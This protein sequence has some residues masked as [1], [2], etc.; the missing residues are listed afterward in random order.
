M[1][2]IEEYYEYSKLANAA[3]IVLDGLSLSST[4]II[5]EA[6][7]QGRIPTSLAEAMFDPALPE[8]QGEAVWSIPE[9]GYYGNDDT[10][11]AATLFERDGEKVLAIRGT[12]PTGD[13]LY[14]DLLRADIAQIG[15]I[16]FALDQTVSMINHI[17]RLRAPKDS[18]VI[19]FQVNVSDEQT[20]NSIAVD[21]GAAYITFNTDTAT[22]YGL[23]GEDE[24]ITVTG[25][26]LGGHLAAM[27]TRLFPDIVKDAYVYNSPGFDPEYSEDIASGLANIATILTGPISNALAE[28][29]VPNELKLTDEFVDFMSDLLPSTPA[30]SFSG[31]PVH[32][33]ESE[34]INPND[35]V[36]IVSSIIT[37]QQVL[38]ESIY[39]ATEDNSHLIEPLMDSLALHEMVHKLDNTTT[40]GDVHSLYL[41]ASN[42]TPATDKNLITSIYKLFVGDKLQGVNIDDYLPKIDVADGFLGASGIGKG[43]TLDRQKHFEAILA[44]ESSQGYKNLIGSAVLIGLGDYSSLSVIATNAKNNIAYRYAL[45]NLD[46][47]VVLGDESIYDKHNTKGELELYDPETQTGTITEE[48]LKDRAEFLTNYIN[49]AINDIT[50]EEDLYG[51]YD[52]SGRIYQ[53]LTDDITFGDPDDLALPRYVF[54]TEEGDPIDGQNGNDHLYGMGGNDEINGGAG[55]DYIEGNQ[56][57]DTLH[58]GDNNDEIHG[59]RDNDHLYGDA[60]RDVLHGEQ[61]G[62]ILYG[63]ADRD[64][65]LGGIGEDVLNGE[66]DVDVLIGGDGNDILS[67]GQGNDILQGND[68]DDV[69]NGDDNN[70]NLSGGAGLD[71]LY[72]GKGQ[73]TLIGGQDG[74]I[75]EGG[76]G[77]DTYIYNHGDGND[78]IRDTGENTLI[79]NGKPVSWGIFVEDGVWQT[80]DGE[81]TFEKNSPLKIT[82]AAGGTLAIEDPNDT[83]LGINLAGSLDGLNIVS[84]P[85]V[86]LEGT[87]GR[88]KIIGGAG[89]DVLIGDAGDDYLFADGEIPIADAI[90]ESVPSPVS[91]DWLTG[92][93]GSDV[94]VGSAGENALLGGSD[95]DLIIGGAGRDYIVGDEMDLYPVDENGNLTNNTWSVHY[96]GNTYEFTT[97]APGRIQG[98]S[99]TATG[100]DTIYAGSGDD[101]VWANGGNDA[102]FGGSG[103]DTIYGAQGNDALLGGDDNDILIGDDS[104]APASEHGN[105]Y[106]DGGGENDQLQG[107]GGDDTLRGGEGNDLLVGDNHSND[108]AYHGNDHLQGDAGDDEL[109]GN[110][111]D[112]QLEG[113]ADN[114]VLFGD[115]TNIDV[116]LHGNDTL[117]GGTGDDILIGGADIDQLLGG[118]GDDQLDGDGFTVD[119]A[120]HNADYLEGGAG[121]DVL[122]G[123]GGSDALYGGDNDD[124]LIGDA[125]YVDTQYHGNDY[126]DGGKGNDSLYGDAGSDVLQGGTGDDILEGGEGNDYLYGGEGNDEIYL[127]KGDD[128]IDGGA[129][130]DTYYYSFGSGDDTIVD[131]GANRL[132]FDFPFDIYKLTLGLGS[133]KITVNDS[134]DAIHLAN[135][136]PNDVYKNVTI[137]TFQFSDGTV[138]SYSQLLDLGFDFDG[139]AGDDTL[140]G[141]SAMDR[142][143]GYGGDDTIIAKAGNDEISG[144]EG[145]DLVFAEAG[146]D[147]IDG[148]AGADTLYGGQGN[149]TYLATEAQDTIIESAGEGTD[150]VETDITYTLGDNLENLTLTGMADLDG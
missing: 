114:D 43:D 101:I 21:N 25:H 119:G 139:T 138:L 124:T 89:D 31:L 62:D 57:N 111:G 77:H 106:I 143:N 134:G 103:E 133:L 131:E 47:F 58:G 24:Q 145:D 52:T 147:E 39:V 32:S 112:D 78:V 129:G 35:D 84:G 15:F 74:D 92:G 73:D 142:M 137:D 141:T 107:Q 63:G 130:V 61:G 69:I 120:Y 41:A 72:G 70:D 99:N 6:N 144:G 2:A 48:Y 40:L 9:Y 82:T 117:D 16:G 7:D 46:P 11:Y 100:N 121:N 67:G 37:N 104:D 146:N 45:V 85:D 109:Q 102:V 118:D 65:L 86:G 93:S 5:R 20:V 148:G 36:S 105:D 12:E 29:I 23:I 54:G 3:Y 50:G 38:G 18:Q 59:G 113:G 91:R 128:Y 94:L 135:F 98:Y 53:D 17:L 4:N 132:V 80:P 125:S 81:L 34:D 19:Q 76:E 110:G 126:L 22:G 10:G 13:N 115:D 27:A 127:G 122:F 26:S 55:D 30:D 150:T 140:I 116:S 42:D 83:D 68:G 71:I 60:G 44:I 28:Y 97:P 96:E 49:R 56:G 136:D 90:N 123:A 108:P 75:L 64:V 33:I 149:D 87:L 8:N 88:D 66:A 79:I 95:S 1:T 51:L 14:L